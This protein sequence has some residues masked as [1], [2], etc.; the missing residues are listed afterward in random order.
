[1]SG[2]ERIGQL[3]DAYVRALHPARLFQPSLFEA[4]FI[5]LLTAG[6]YAVLVS[7]S[8]SGRITELCYFIPAVFLGFWVVSA[9]WLWMVNSLRELRRAFLCSS[10]LLAAHLPTLLVLAPYLHLYGL[11]VYG[12]KGLYVWLTVF[13]FIAWSMLRLR[14]ICH[15]LGMNRT[16]TLVAVL[17]PMVFLVVTI[18]FVLVY[19]SNGNFSFLDFFKLL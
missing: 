13:L 9:F 11:G 12:M 4:I 1:M 17:L 2:F 3:M 15:T 10:T 7:V 6:L 18:H 5:Y 16:R 8:L 14:T 19:L